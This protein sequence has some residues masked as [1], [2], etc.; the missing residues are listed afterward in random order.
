M[1]EKNKIGVIGRRGDVLTFQAA[2]FATYQAE[3]VPDAISFDSL[4]G[5]LATEAFRSGKFY[6]QDP[7]PAHVCKLLKDHAELLPPE[8]NFIDLCQI[9]TNFCIY[10]E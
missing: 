7:A 1:S 9:C 5:V 8:V 2:G 6:I 3:S 10:F 4:R